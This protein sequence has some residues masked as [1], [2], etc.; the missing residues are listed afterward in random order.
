MHLRLDSLPLRQTCAHEGNGLIDFHRVF[1][2]EAFVSACHFVDYAVL[3]PGAS[4]GIHTHGDDEEIY[5][6]LEG[7]GVMHLDGEEFRVGPGSVIKNRRRGT[8]GLRNDGAT[9]LRLFVVEIGGVADAPPE[10][11]G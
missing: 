3:P 5:L 8:H 10:H 9:P 2:R 11:R 1:P 4:I 6:V 7:Q